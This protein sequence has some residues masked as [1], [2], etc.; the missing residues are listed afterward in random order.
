[1]IRKF[2][3]ARKL[4]PYKTCAMV[5][6]LKGR[7]IR[8]CP[9]MEPNTED[10]PSIYYEM[11]E[12]ARVRFDEFHSGASNHEV[13]QVDNPELP[14]AVRPS[15]V[16]SFMEG[17]LKAVVLDTDQDSIKVQFKQAG[18]LDAGGVLNIPG[19]RLSTMP[20]LKAE[21]KDDI[22]GCALKNK[23]DYICVPN[24]TSVKD[25]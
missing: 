19:N 4:R 22:L 5:L 6:D 3:E 13:I 18:Y 23:F 8:C 7:E 25:V 16:I 14:K 21:D 11:G 17:E 12:V 9:R 1:M 20:V 2:F 24:I 15:D 10:S